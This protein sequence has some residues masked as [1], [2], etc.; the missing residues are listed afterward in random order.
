MNK[1]A[2]MREILE[3]GIRIVT[4]LMCS[5]NRK[6]KYSWAIKD[7]EQ[8]DGIHEMTSPVDFALSMSEVLKC[9]NDDTRRG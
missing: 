3:T 1:L 2:A 8:S 5:E 7:L 9:I 6:I 4:V